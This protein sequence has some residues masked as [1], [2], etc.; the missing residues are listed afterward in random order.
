MY[1]YLDWDELGHLLQPIIDTRNKGQTNVMPRSTLF[2]LVTSFN[3][4]TIYAEKEIKTKLD[5]EMT[6]FP[7]L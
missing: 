2:D 7:R 3:K 6:E 5:R 1:K 4:L